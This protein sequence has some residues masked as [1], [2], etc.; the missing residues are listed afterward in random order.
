MKAEYI[1]YFTGPDLV[2]IGHIIDT[3]TALDVVLRVNSVD[4]L[5]VTLPTAPSWTDLAQPGNR[6]EILRDDGTGWAYLTGGPIE[7]PGDQDWSSD[8]Q[9]ADPGTMVI[10]AGDDRAGLAGRITYPNPAADAEH[11]TATAR[12]TFTGVNAKTIMRT[13]VDEQA[14]PSAI[15]G[16]PIPGLA[17]G[18]SAA[19]GTTINYSSRFGL[20]TDDLRA[21]ATAGG[22]LAY[23]I[24]RSTGALLFEVD[25][26]RDRSGLVRYSKAIGN[27]RSYSFRHQAPTFTVAIVGGDGTGTGRTIVEVINTAALAAGWP[28]IESFINNDSNDTTELTN[29]GLDA[30]AQAAEQGSISITAVDNA[31]QRFGRDYGLNDLVTVEI[32]G[33]G[34]LVAPV[35]S[36][37]IAVRTD[38]QDEG[39]TISPQIGGDP[40]TDAGTLRRLRAIEKRLGRIERG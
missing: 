31:D 18:S 21:I 28:R 23:R 32:D 39:E 11:Q 14:G 5:S 10:Y 33:A 17:L 19:A 3:W 37:N 20:L 9:N 22:N 40:I 7:R 26:Q 36:V 25:A 30:L 6:L 38:G 2:P 8:G 29:A 27:L 34:T 1:V 15:T 16:R 13:L 35:T 12:R 24:D 4:T